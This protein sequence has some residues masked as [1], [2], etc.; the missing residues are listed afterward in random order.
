MSGENGSSTAGVSTIRYSPLAPAG[1]ARDRNGQN[2][3]VKR[4]CCARARA[5]S[6]AL[7]AQRP[8]IDPVAARNPPL[9]QAARA[10]R[11][12]PDRRRA[13]AHPDHRRAHAR[14]RQAYAVA[15]R[16]R[17]RR[18]ARRA[19]AR[20]SAKRWP[21]TIPARPPA[22]HQ[23]EDEFAHYAGQ[24]VVL[25]S[26]PVEDHKIP[27]W[28]QELSCGAAGMNLLLAAHALGYRRRLGDR[29]ARL[30]GTRPRRLL[31]ARRAD[32]RLHLHRPR[33]RASSR[34]GR[35]PT[36]ADVWQAV[37]A[38]D[39]LILLLNFLRSAVL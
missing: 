34:S 7:D 28:E 39:T 20:C 26:A 35:G 38:A 30:F 27:V 11:P 29:L 2:P 6:A 31:R 4:D 3:L 14:S 23:K 25:I 16:H 15:L 36:L 24:L 9:G 5:L 21:R 19:S 12:G 22:H 1:A 17:R 32:R 37:A 10:G 13:G 18:P 33:R 8:L